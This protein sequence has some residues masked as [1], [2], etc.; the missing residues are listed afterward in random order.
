MVMI[1]VSY[2]I[3]D[4]IGNFRRTMFQ[5]EQ[6]IFILEAISSFSAVILLGL[7]I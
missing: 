6:G 4:K 5:R 7:S 1:E 2:D 3:N